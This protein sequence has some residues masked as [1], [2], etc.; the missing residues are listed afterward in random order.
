MVDNPQLKSGLPRINGYT[1][2]EWIASSESTKRFKAFSEKSNQEVL[3]TFGTAQAYTE[4]LKTL[5]ETSIQNHFLT[6]QNISSPHL[7]PLL[8]AGI[9]DGSPYCA[10]PYFSEKTL[11]ELTGQPRDWRDAFKL[12]LPVTEALEVI[13]Q[14]NLSHRD[15]QPCNIYFDPVEGIK[16]T[17]QSLFEVSPAIKDSFTY[18]GLGK[19]EPA[20]TAPE[21]W[22]GQSSAL[23]DQYSFG[24]I[25]YEI[26]T[27]KL[28][29][30][31]DN[32]VS[33]LVLQTS[34][35]FHLPSQLVTGVPQIVDAFIVK[36]LSNDPSKRF[37]TMS[38]IRKVMEKMQTSPKLEVPENE[39][40]GMQRELNPA[41]PTIYT[42]STSKNQDKRSSLKTEK[43]LAKARKKA[44]KSEE[45]TPIGCGLIGLFFLF[46]LGVVL[47][48]AI[49]MLAGL[50]LK[51]EFFVSLVDQ[52]E[53]WIMNSSFLQKLIPAGI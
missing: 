16:L 20:Y 14:H 31:A 4:S 2:I 43:K 32:I 42:F 24:V 6:Y 15:I 50:L 30:E 41:S 22:Q 21:V 44:N 11:R 51:V 33:L 9:L 40:I 47:F 52:I 45:K 36:L 5:A 1:N 18:T 10:T 8:D 13:H 12:M 39:P 25:L 29:F 23:S 3:L 35:S 46:L 49:V 53:I 17:N 34:G 7:L 19:I 28:P 26:L 48:L 38:Q 37:E 27:G